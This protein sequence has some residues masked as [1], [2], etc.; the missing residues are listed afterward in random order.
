MRAFIYNLILL[1]AR[2]LKASGIII[3]LFLI[4][5]FS[6]QYLDSPESYP[7][8]FKVTSV[9]KKMA[10]P[11]L[12]QI[13]LTIPHNFKGTDFS[14]IVL[15]ALIF[16][17]LN[18]FGSLAAQAERKLAQQ[19][20]KKRYIEWRNKIKKDMP[21]SHIEGL[22]KELKH[23]DSLID[24]QD[25]K[26]LLREF[27]LIKSR[28]DSMGQFLT[29]LSIDIIDSTGMKRDEDKYI[30]SYDFDRYNELLLGCLKEFKV[31]K[32]AM[33]P[34]GMMACFKECKDAVAAGKTM[35]Q[36]LQ[37]FNLED[38]KM[39]SEF[40]IRCGINGG[41]VYIDDETALEQISDRTIDIAGHMQKNA[42]PDSIFIAASTLDKLPEKNGFIETTL[43]I[44]EQ[45]VYKWQVLPEQLNR[46]R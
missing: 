7:I 6:A 45:A 32:Y 4:V 33:T 29:F 27:A 41:Y 19:R 34:D 3:A 20:E 39:R 11:A 21:A 36:R 25:R 22:E 28:L 23:E 12:Q 2:L 35:I 30:A 42:E 18:I 40:H 8:L 5:M 26:Q 44:D 16:L 10:E 31:F 43:V 17:F 37:Q 14:A 9:T 15:V 24:F 38:K 13:R 46:A 1:L